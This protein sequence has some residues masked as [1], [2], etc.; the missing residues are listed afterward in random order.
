MRLYLAQEVL[1]L[2]DRV[3]V[4]P[5]HL[6]PYTFYDLMF[7]GSGGE[8][9]L[10]DDMNVDGSIRFGQGSLDANT[11]NLYVQGFWDMESDGS[12]GHGNGTVI[13]DGTAQTI[14]GSST[15]LISAKQMSKIIVMSL[16][17]LRGLLFNISLM[18]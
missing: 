14:T 11:R 9:S 5:S 3:Q 17:S 12:F 7:N 13:F 18:I 10:G 8:W 4:I 6:M 15:F 1:S 16:L 2:T